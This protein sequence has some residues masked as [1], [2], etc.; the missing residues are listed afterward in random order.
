MEKN[1]AT[2]K[3]SNPFQPYSV[4]Y[5]DLF[6][7]RNDYIDTI[8]NRLISVKQARTASFLLYGERGIGKTSLAKFIEAICHQNSDSPYNLNF[9]TS[10]YTVGEQQTLQSVLEASLNNLTDNLP[11]TT[12]SQLSQKLGNL[13]QNGKFSFGAFGINAALDVNKPEGQ[14]YILKDQIISSM[15][16]IIKSSVINAD[17]NKQDG[18]FVII[19]DIHNLRDLNGSAQTLR[20]IIN[21]LDF[22][23]LGY[24]SFLLTS[25]EDGVN[26][27]F[28]GDPSAR[29]SFDFMKLDV[30]SNTEAQDLIIRGFKEID[31]GFDPDVLAREVDVAGGYPHALQVLGHHLIKTDNNHYIDIDDWKQAII[32]SAQELQKKDFFDFYNFTGKQTVKEKIMNILA[33]N[34]GHSINKQML[35]QILGMTAY[36]VLNALIKQGAVQQHSGNGQLTLQSKLL[37]T[38]ISFY[39]KAQEETSQLY[40]K[41]ETDLNKIIPSN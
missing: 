10:Y 21:S 15:S 22:N 6:A 35:A 2:N 37:A 29:R 41:T 5:T 33:L 14:K 12:L 20:N 16:N 32:A 24:F 9:V 23:N 11:Q 34:N 3:P 40:S 7:G 19:D 31:I 8:A 36:R 25:S 26:S 17:K 38:A 27:F 13:F 30:M 39:L 28:A 1:H 18:L 4:A